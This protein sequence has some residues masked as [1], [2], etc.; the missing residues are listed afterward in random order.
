[1][2]F[3]KEHCNVPMNAIAK[4]LKVK[5]EKVKRIFSQ[6][7]ENAENAFVSEKHTNKFRKLH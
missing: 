7:I 4:R 1:M 5:Y 6:Q 2:K 3:L